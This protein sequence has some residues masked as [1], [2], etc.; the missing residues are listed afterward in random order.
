M[1]HTNKISR[2]IRKAVHS[3]TATMSHKPW[4]QSC[5]RLQSACLFDSFL[6]ELGDHST[7]TSSTNEAV[8][9]ETILGDLSAPKKAAPSADLAACA[10]PS[11]IS[12]PSAGRGAR[13]HFKSH[14]THLQRLLGSRESQ[15]TIGWKSCAKPMARVNGT[16]TLCNLYS[17]KTE[18]KVAKITRLTVGSSSFEVDV[19]A[20]V[21]SPRAS[22]SGSIIEVRLRRAL[23]AARKKRGFGG[24]V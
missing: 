15:Q 3:N 12:P 5:S 23:N 17:A 19:G 1:D 14:L 8:P 24:L 16:S 2:P 21:G 20:D 10:A 9:A 7:T 11:E 18:A 6:N 13:R 22:A 4:P